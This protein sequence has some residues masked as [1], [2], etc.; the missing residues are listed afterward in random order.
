ML[1]TSSLMKQMVKQN[2]CLWGLSHSL[3]ILL[4]FNLLPSHSSVPSPLLPQFW[5]GYQPIT[6]FLQGDS[7]SPIFLIIQFQ[8]YRILV[9]RIPLVK[10]ICPY[11]KENFWPSSSAQLTWGSAIQVIT[12][13][14]W[15]TWALTWMPQLSLR[16]DT[17]TLTKEWMD[18]F[19]EMK[20]LKEFLKLSIKT[21]V[22][23]SQKIKMTMWSNNSTL[24]IY[25]K[26]WKQRLI[27]T[28]AH[29][30]S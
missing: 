21:L 30:R 1:Q 16:S 4:L 19:P 25:P 24:S 10:R 13:S 26:N 28:F 5:L 11:S 17:G 18:V 6:L 12:I 22:K 9:F 2:E 27:Q 23:F 29:P 15:P 3:S 8:A 7:S 14:C 20:R